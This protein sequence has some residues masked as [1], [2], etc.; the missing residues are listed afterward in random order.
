MFEG[1]K[2]TCCRLFGNIANLDS[3]AQFLMIVSSV[4]YKGNYNYDQFIKIKGDLVSHVLRN[5][6]NKSM[7]EIFKIEE[8]Q[9][10]IK[11][12][13]ENHKE[14]MLKFAGNMQTLDYQRYSEVLDS[15]MLKF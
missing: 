11:Y 15:W 12:L 9:F 6:T 8:L 14:R 2:S 1:F 13:A 10:A 4:K 3:I 5:F 7:E